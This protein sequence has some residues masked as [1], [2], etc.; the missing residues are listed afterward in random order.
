[1][2]HPGT[3][4]SWLGSGLTLEVIDLSWFTRGTSP[5]RRPDGKLADLTGPGI[6]DRWGVTA[7]DLG[8][9]VLAPN[10]KL[11]AVFGD[12]FS[13]NRVGDGTWRS[14]VVLIGTG[15]ARSPVAWECAGGP[16]PEFAEQLWS[17][18]HDTTGPRWTQGGIS[19]VLPSDLLR[20][21]DSLYLHAMVNRGF[22][23]VIWTEIWRSDDCG[24]SWQHMGEKAKFPADLHGGLAQC[25]S[26]DYDPDDDWV[27]VASTSFK[28]D[29]GIILRR[30]RPAGIGDR[31]EYSGWGF[32]AGRWAWDSEPTPITPG[33][34]T[35]GELS[36]R[37][38]AKGTWILG[39]F[40]S[41]KYALGYRVVTGPTANMYEAPIQM[42]VTGSAWNAEDH[43]ASRVAQL[44][45]GYVLPGSRLDV[46]GGVGLVVSQWNTTS[47]W[48]YRAMQFTSTLQDTTRGDGRDPADPINL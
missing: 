21:G 5:R 44:Y 43:A 11:V 23:E 9:T 48:P 30:V 10:G 47:G 24:V 6:S 32:A 7:T 40:V 12:T 16:N 38:L 46:R 4:D 29:K 1:M 41:S 14:P 2:G 28:R 42:P 20:V 18:V 37:R 22:P 26:W 13:G 27:Y 33:G 25:W 35:W 36:F 34:E 17:Y 45:G 8:A 39:G 3:A 15:D 19:T 31:S